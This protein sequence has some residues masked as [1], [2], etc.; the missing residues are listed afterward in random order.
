MISYRSSRCNKLGVKMGVCG[1]P[2]AKERSTLVIKKKLFLL[3]ILG[4]QYIA[5]IPF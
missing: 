4:I 2:N 3:L 1:V 5:L